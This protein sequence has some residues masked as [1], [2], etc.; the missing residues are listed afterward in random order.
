MDLCQQVDTE[1]TREANKEIGYNNIIMPV[2]WI[3]LK[4]NARSK[5]R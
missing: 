4:A 5:T 1:F 2:T 3:I